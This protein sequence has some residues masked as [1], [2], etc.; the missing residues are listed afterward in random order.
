MSVLCQKQTLTS[1]MSRER[2]LEALLSVRL[3]DPD[4]MRFSHF[5]SYVWML[6]QKSGV[7]YNFYNPTAEAQV[8]GNLLKK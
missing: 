1:E 5:S 6:N 8:A 3:L 4:V 2:R 7:R